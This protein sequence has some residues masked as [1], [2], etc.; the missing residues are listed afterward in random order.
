MI[1]PDSTILLDYLLA[2]TSK[3]VETMFVYPARMRENLDLL[4]G[5]AA[6]KPGTEGPIDLSFSAK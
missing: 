6:N 1:L 2:K 3:L 4:K 5:F